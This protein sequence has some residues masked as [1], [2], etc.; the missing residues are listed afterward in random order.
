M[1][2]ISLTDS[3][4]EPRAFWAYLVAA[5]ASTGIVP[6]DHPLAQLVPGLGD[7]NEFMSRLMTEL[8]TLPSTVVLVLDDFHVIHEPAVHER[9]AEVLAYQVE[10]LRLVLDPLGP[11][12]AAAQVAPERPAG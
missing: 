8:A 2:W 9:L 12:A 11:P 4:N 5:V 3:D 6:P 1:A 10:Q 7:E